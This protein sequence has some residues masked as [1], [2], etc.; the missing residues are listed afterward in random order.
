MVNQSREKGG[1]GRL[2]T[3][4]EAEIDIRRAD[5]ETK[6][7][8]NEDG[9]DCELSGFLGGGRI[10]WKGVAVVYKSYSIRVIARRAV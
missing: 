3:S 4:L 2:R 9:A 1:F 7:G 6:K 10:W 8:A 5:D